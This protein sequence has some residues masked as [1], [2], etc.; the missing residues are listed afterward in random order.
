MPHPARGE[1]WG[2]DLTPVLGH[3]QGGRGPALVVSV[4]AFNAG[5]A[6]LVVILPLTSKAKGIPFHIQI[7][8]PSGGLEQVS[9]VKCEDIRSISRQRLRERWGTVSS[10]T[11]LQIEDRLRILLN[12]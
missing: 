12:L 8:P 2:V 7:K 11:L 5:P 1:I 10:M 4:D 9:Y 6:E 3:E